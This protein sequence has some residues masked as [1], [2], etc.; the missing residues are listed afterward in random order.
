L[1]EA[2]LVGVPVALGE[3]SLVGKR[4]FEAGNS[5]SV[6]LRVGN[7]GWFDILRWGS[8]LGDGQDGAF[9]L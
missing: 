7:R 8:R 3:G 6:R 2:V 9:G 4:G 1:L 5:L